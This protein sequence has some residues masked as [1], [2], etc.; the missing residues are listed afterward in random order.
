M[1]E[2]TIRVELPAFGHSFVLNKVSLKSSVLDVK[3]KIFQTCSGS[4]RVDG[5]RIIWRGRFLQDSEKL[6]ELWVSTA[7]EDEPHLVFHLAVHPS[8]WSASPP[9]ISQPV[10]QAQP[11]AQ[12][13]RMR[14]QPPQASLP[15]ASN[16]GHPLL[17]VLY[18]HQNALIALM[19]GNL[20]LSRES[21]E[22]QQSKELAMSTVERMGWKWPSIL[23]EPFPAPSEGG[24]K[25]ERTIL[26]GQSYLSLCNPDDAP[27][28][29]QV[30]ALKVLACTFPLLKLPMVTHIP[31]RSI[32]S[33]SI[34]IPPHVN[35]VLQQLGLPQL[36]NHNAIANPNPNPVIRP[37]LLP[38][39]L[40]LLR[41]LLILYFFA[42]ARKPMLG[43]LLLWLV[44]ELWQRGVFNNRPAAE[45][46]RPQ[47]Q[48]QNIQGAAAPAAAAPAA[49]N[50]AQNN[51]ARQQ[52]AG[53][54]MNA[55]LD[56]LANYDIQAEEAIMAG[57][58]DQEPRFTH[59][60]ITFFGLLTATVHPAVWDRRR[61][62]LRRRE[63]RIR[64]EELVRQAAVEE[65]QA[66]D[67]AR[68]QRRAQLEAQ[69][70]RRPQWLQNYVERVGM[71]EESE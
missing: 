1:A 36:P 44:Y 16:A 6:E 28:P 46:Q 63:G 62:L 37:F 48:Q 35:Q 3:E 61:A 15:A 51:P 25:Y 54:Q 17:Y 8:A 40:H 47:Q 29:L 22:L 31:S 64:T 10:Q 66:V 57:T 4:P 39:L 67:E 49:P 23:D 21:S 18:L 70:A 56:T 5:Q 68:A 38:T 50:A 24:L 52:A 12:P 34:P 2:C 30:H 32:P 69:H 9:T 14:P 45:Q 65:G 53:T 13:F 19:Q 27:N 7:A 41:I 43:I 33:N 20:V 59:K 58:D 42:P 71:V 11:P 55:V 60:L 26:E